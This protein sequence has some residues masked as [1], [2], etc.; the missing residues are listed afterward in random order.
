MAA[1]PAPL[2]C[3]AEGCAAPSTSACARCRTAEYCG[4]PCQRAHW[5][6][7]KPRCKELEA[8][9]DAAEAAEAAA[10][11]AAAAGGGGAG[12]D[13]PPSA[14]RTPGV[15]SGLECRVQD[16][17]CALGSCGAALEEGGANAVCNGCRSV[18]YCDV[19]CQTAHWEA[20]MEACLEA[21]AA[22]VNSGDVHQ[23]DE[24]G[25][26]VLRTLL[27]VRSEEYGA[28]DERT[29]D[30]MSVLGTLMQCQGKL[31]EAKELYCECLAA[32]RAALGSK[33]VGTIEGMRN[34]AD[35]LHAQGNL[36][37]AGP[38][39]REALD[40]ARATLGP[41]NGAHALQRLTIQRLCLAQLSLLL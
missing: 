2:H 32:R 38:L 19:D 39:M 18:V 34:L 28:S 15:Y 33:H 13:K 9:A 24:G 23:D 22:R 36:V 6:A 1:A 30:C 4:A 35:L 29:L 3:W 14:P 26:Y 5:P 7:H 21:V 41:Q 11:A 27:N 12:E 31:A 16:Y 40:T 8:A 17:H 20:H 25:E 10:A 37:E